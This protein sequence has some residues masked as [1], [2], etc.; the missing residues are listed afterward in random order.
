MIR[1]GRG[2]R[3]ATTAAAVDD[4]GGHPVLPEHRRPAQ[5][6]VLPGRRTGGGTAGIGR[7]RP[8]RGRTAARRRDV[9]ATGAAL[10]G[11][12]TRRGAGGR[13]ENREEPGRTTAG[14]LNPPAGPGATGTGTA[15]RLARAASGEV[16]PG[17]TSM[18][19]EVSLAVTS[20]EGRV[21]ERRDPVTRSR[22]GLLETKSWR[23]ARDNISS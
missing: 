11:R 8:V 17:S 18:R 21:P 6:P 5:P 20:T 16:R 7:V 13:A 15:C 4:A 3:H 2:G 1:D 12:T 23:Q 9:G 10:H 22:F 14:E 19:V